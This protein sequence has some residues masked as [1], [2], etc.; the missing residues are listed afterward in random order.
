M[1]TIRVLVAD[2]HGVVRKGITFLLGQEKDI[3]IV[4]EAE[5]GRQAVQLAAELEPKVVIMD[6]AMPHLNGIDATAQI[7]R[8]GRTGVIILS[9][10]SDEEFLIRAL[11]AGAKGYLLK[12]SAEADLVRAV[13]SVAAGRTFFSPAI[14]HMLLDD[15]V[16]RLQQE[17]IQDSYDLLTDREKEVLQLLAQGKSNKEVAQVLSLSPHTVETH[18]THFMQKLDLHNTAE[19]VIYA[20][21]KKI[22]S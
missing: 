20:M 21:R 6:I 11:T 7:A 10:Y 12:D 22:I 18:R 19:I 14:A 13:R 4:A 15:Y 2:D 5:D 16:R 9:M 8:E 1:S 3:E 17:R